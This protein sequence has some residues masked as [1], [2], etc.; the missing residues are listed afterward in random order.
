MID[1]PLHVADIG[2]ETTSISN[3]RAQAADLLEDALRPV[4]QPEM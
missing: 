4:F 1:S 2:L 3:I